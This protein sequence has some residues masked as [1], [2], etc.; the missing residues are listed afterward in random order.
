M[1]E[2]SVG[3]TEVFALGSMTGGTYGTREVAS[4]SALGVWVLGTRF[5]ATG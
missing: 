4:P 3:S 5:T 2:I 1:G